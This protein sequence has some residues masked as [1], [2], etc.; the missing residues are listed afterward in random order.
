M[1][2]SG[3]GRRTFA[4][5]NY[6]GVHPEIMQALLDANNGHASS[7]G[8]DPYTE[9]AITTFRKLFGSDTEVFFVYNGTGANVLALSGITHS[10]NSVLCAE[11][12]H[13]NVDESTAPEKFTGCKLVTIQTT[14]GK[15]TP[16]LIRNKIQRVGDQHHPQVKAISISQ[17]TEFGT[18]YKAEEVREIAR[19]AK[20][21]NLL[22]HMDGARISNAAAA[23]N[24]DFITFSKDAGVDILSFGGTKNGLMFGEAIL[25]FNKDIAKDLIYLRKQGMQLHSKMRFISAQFNRM[26]SGNLWKETA[27]HA[28]QMAQI[29]EKGLRQF[30]QIK[31]TNAVQANGV[32]AI[33]PPAII[34][35]L[36]QQSFFY[37]WNESTF[38]VR[39]MCSW[40][41]HPEDVENFIEQVKLEIAGL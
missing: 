27:T 16:E 21:N 1:E 15:L 32:F 19:V 14:D 4:S 20:E 10:Y 2:S 23:L 28:N 22:L 37:V 36:Q 34:P 3:W 26:L 11:S 30:S 13:I 41:T 33:F 18:L 12:A 39:L 29:L 35:K 24:Q 40:D 8:N 5:D 31:I 6:A 9:S 25:V 38:E 17:T 7:Y